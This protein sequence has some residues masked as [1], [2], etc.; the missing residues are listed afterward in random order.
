MACVLPFQAMKR[1][2]K[3]DIDAKFKALNTNGC[4]VRLLVERLVCSRRRE[5]P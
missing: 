3:E 1:R 2:A 4:S 5:S